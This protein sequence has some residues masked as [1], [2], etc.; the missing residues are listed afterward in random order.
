MLLLKHRRDCC[1]LR[2]TCLATAIVLWVGLLPVMADRRV[3][4]VI[5]NS[6][7]LDLPALENP[8]NDA[9]DVGRASLTRPRTF[10]AYGDEARCDDWAAGT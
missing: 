7:H 8:R 2:A 3:A 9:E 4:L 10:E 1:T 6:D 5:G